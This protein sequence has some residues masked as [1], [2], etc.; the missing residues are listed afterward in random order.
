MRFSRRD[1]DYV[2]NGAPTIHQTAV[3]R[4]RGGAHRYAPIGIPR[5][6]QLLTDTGVVPQ[7]TLESGAE[8]DTRCSKQEEIWNYVWRR[9][10]IYFTTVFASLYIAIYPLSRIIP[11]SGEFRSGLSFVSAAV[12]AIGQVLPGALA[13]WIDA[14]ARDP[15]HFLVLGLL[16]ALLIWLGVWL[17]GKIRDRMERV[18][19]VAL[20]PK[21]SKLEVI[22]CTLGAILAAYALLHGH[23]PRLLQMPAAIDQFLTDHIS[24]SVKIIAAATFVALFTPGPAVFHLRSWVGYRTGV[25][26][27][28]LFILPFSFA[29]LFLWLG[30]TF[31]SHVAFGL[32]EANGFVCE[33]SAGITAAIASDPMGEKGTTVENRGLQACMSAGLARCPEDGK[34]PTCSNAREAYCGEGQP[35]CEKRYKAGCDPQ[36]ANCSYTVPVCRVQSPALPGAATES[37]VA[38][39]AIC[40]SI[41]EKGPVGKAK[42]FEIKDVC[43]ATGV[44]LEEGQRYELIVR[45]PSPADP[46]YA[47]TAWRDD[48]KDIVSTRGTGS[49]TIAG[50]LRESVLWPLKRHLFNARF[51]VV[52]RVGSVGSDEYVLEADDDTKSDILPVIIKPKRNGELFLYVN[53]F[54]WGWRPYFNYFYKENTG[55]ATVVVQ[56]PGQSN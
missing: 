23:L 4:A 22:L 28:K 50:K 9:R 39:L 42:T 34:P 44:W 35:I 19:R 31:T 24:L 13:P 43:H 27:I 54:V 11:A 38:G 47:A 14:Y 5:H 20:P 48:G 46:D 45:P 36:K 49:G 52:A 41:C 21:R 51:K 3:Q 6:Y 8:A 1:G 32:Q 37:R 53:E 40:A 18:W 56:R 17:G 2:D 55:H 29:A 7:S 10:V 26:W 25:R 15:S 30:V 12:R 33:Q 16:V